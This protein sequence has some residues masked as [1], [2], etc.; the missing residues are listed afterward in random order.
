MRLPSQPLATPRVLGFTSAVAI[1]MG[2][3]IGS[4]VF[5]LPA[6]L[7]AYRGR[8]PDWV[9][10]LDR[11]IGVLAFVFARLAGFDPQRGSLR[12]SAPRVRR[13]RRI[14]RRVGLLDPDLDDNAALAVALVE[15]LNPF[16]PVD[17]PRPGAAASMAVGVVWL[18]NPVH[19]AAVRDAGRVQLVTT[20][21]KILPLVVRRLRRPPGLR[22]VPLRWPAVPGRPRELSAPPS[23]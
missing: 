23:R 19:F 8:E 6:S 14:P 13:P 15:Y 16:V 5:L 21:L 12:L 11:R 3:M 2:N 17:R 20:A 18:S 1:V 4:G 22:P 10:H 9:D 7:A